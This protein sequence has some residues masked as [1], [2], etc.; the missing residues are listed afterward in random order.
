MPAAP[1]PKRHPY[2]QWSPDARALDLVGDKWTL[3]I[4][5]DLAGG[6]RRFVEL[7]RVLPGISTEQLRSRLNRMVA[8]GLL[9]RQRYRE[10]PPRVDYELTERAR[11]V[12]PVVSALARWGY[13]WA[14]SPPRPGEAIDV[15][16]ILRSATGMPVP[17]RSGTGT[18]ELV[19]TGRDH[20]TYAMRLERD[21]LTISERSEPGD[22]DA[23]VTGSETAWIEAFSPS[24]GRGGL[25]FEGDER[26]AESVLALCGGGAAASSSRTAV[27]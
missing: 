16:A 9:T 21:R 1:P 23:R 14:W 27:A 6:P 7:Q 8:D 22:A 11:D 15:G 19:V 17:P 20:A 18:V 10:V 3:L 26:L 4:I 12:L 25:S 2:H 24:G 13:E 5:R